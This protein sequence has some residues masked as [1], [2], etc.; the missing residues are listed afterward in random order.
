MD[1]EAGDACRYKA[2]AKE[3][4]GNGTG[5]DLVC[6][7][8]YRKQCMIKLY[9]ATHTHTHTHT[10][11]GIYNWW[12]LSKLCVFYQEIIQ[13]IMIRIGQ[14]MYKGRIAKIIQKLKSQSF[15]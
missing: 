10:H 9:R 2:V 7:S 6:N 3:P 8:G 12:T 13:E 15:I 14:A 5:R 1:G 11:E 4:H